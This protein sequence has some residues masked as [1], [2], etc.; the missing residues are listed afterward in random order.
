[1]PLSD[2]EQATLGRL[3]QRLNR[4]LRGHQQ[5]GRGARTQGFLSLDAYYDGEQRLAQ[6][7]LAVPEDLR[8]FVTIV[9]WPGSYV[10]ALVE[11]RQVEGFRLPGSPVADADL[12]EVWQA[13]DMDSE[14]PM[15]RVDASVFGRSYYSV[16]TNEETPEIPLITVDSPLEMTH[17]WSN[18]RRRVTAAA[19]FYS[20]DEGAKKVQRSTLYEDGVTSWCVKGPRGWQLEDR[21]DHG[22]PCPVVPSVIGSRTH[23]RYGRSII[24]KTIPLTDAGARALT[25]AQVATEV[26][27]IP[28]RTAAG[29][30]QADF[31]DPETGEA[32]TAWEAYF[33]A[34]WA[35]SNPDARF[36]QFSAADLGNF[37]KITGHYAQ[38]MAG[39]TGLPMRYLGQL[40]DNPPSADGIRADESRLVRA[41]ESQNAYEA[42]AL[43]RVMRL[44]H[45]FR[46]GDDDASLA[47][48]ETIHRDPST[49]TTAQAADAAV[50][51]FQAGIIS[52]RQARRDIGYSPVAIDN[53]EADDESEALDPVTRAVVDGL[54]RA[55][56]GA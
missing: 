24:G 1:M 3:Q 34:V 20:D 30:T 22:F 12:W 39:I 7:G 29:M 2:D 36:H 13:N 23:A 40:S 11:R 55:D 42:G 47:R 38:L 54:P 28:Q 44:V 31:K 17:E 21:D 14:S 19:R 4:D 52:K 41:C 32:L 43:E 25:L 49:P 46:S 53:M 10:D 15:A 9:G 26:M 48:M 35:T 16:G 37:V 5:P 50:K 6:L 8:D 51:L 18:R 33:G 45:Q 27:G 56:V